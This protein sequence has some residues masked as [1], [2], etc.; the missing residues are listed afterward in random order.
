MAGMTDM[1]P[2]AEAA[3]ETHRETT[4]G[5]FGVQAHTAP[6]AELNFRDELN[7]ANEAYWQNTERLHEEVADFLLHGMP[8]GAHRVVFEP[9]DQG[10]YL[11]VSRAFD[12][13]GAEIDTE[14]DYDRWSD[15]DDVISYLGHPDDNRRIHEVLTGADG[16]TFEWTR[17]EETTAEAADEAAATTRA[18]I[19]LLVD[20]RRELAAQSQAGAIT[21]IRRLLPEGSRLVLTWGDQGGPDY[22]SAE[23]VIL[24]DGTELD[25]EEAWDRDID[26]DS[27]DQAASDIR[28]T[29]DLNITA[30]EGRRDYFE[31][32]Q[33]TAPAGVEK[34]SGIDSTKLAAELRK[35]AKAALTTKEA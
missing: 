11:T 18:G 5:R 6:E 32:H 3:R 15:V 2:A 13:D 33:S 24:A 4:T 22:L 19:D 12:A 28:N 8:A 34:V 17:T 35:Q 9:S 20:E 29:D 23:T 25:D 31:L 21:A 1:N 26:W 30:I 27:I 14:E 16:D 7:T 10:D